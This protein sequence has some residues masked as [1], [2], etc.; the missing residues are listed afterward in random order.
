M[1]EYEKVWSEGKKDSSGR[2]T[3]SPGWVYSPV[4]S[5]LS[6]DE[7]K[8]LDEV[9]AHLREIKKEEIK[10]Q[11]RYFKCFVKWFSLISE[12][13]AKNGIGDNVSPHDFIDVDK[14]RDLAIYVEYTEALDFSTAKKKVLPLLWNNFSDETVWQIIE[15]LGLLDKT[16]SN[17]LDALIEEVFSKYPDKVAEHKSGKKNLVGL[18]MGEIMRSGKVKANPKELNGLISK[19]LEA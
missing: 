9:E 14:L 18:F 11:Q 8:Y 4:K 2:I 13:K 3:I 17:E 10:R 19:K 15:R 6:E 5:N 7:Q 16:D 12:F 1:T